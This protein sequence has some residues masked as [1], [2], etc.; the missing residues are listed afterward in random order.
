MANKPVTTAV[1]PVAGLGT[2]FLPATKAVA[3]ETL[4]VVDKPIIQYAVEEAI[5]AGITKLVFVTGRSKRAIEDHFD[6]SVELETE[7]EANGKTRM[8][9]LVR[10]IL[11]EGVQC[12]YTRQAQPLGLGHAV[13]CAQPA[14]GDEPFA[15][16]LP[17][18]LID[19]DGL[20]ATAELAQAWSDTGCSVVA[21]QQ[22]PREHTQRYGVAAVEDASATVSRMTGMVEKPR[23][24]DAPSDL[25]VVGRYVLSPS[26]L[27]EAAND[28]PRCRRRDPADRR[29]RGAHS[30]RGR[31][32]VTL[33]RHAL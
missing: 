6:R 19:S 11:P 33:L 16:L 15:V 30:G 25:G 14:V 23:P 27:R 32:R 17:D 4:P 21:V 3:K 13:L 2:R 5:A 12:V 26:I 31:L 22:V 1:F 29:H 28:R 20:G 18:D 7:L 8:L 9:D 10:N 24:E